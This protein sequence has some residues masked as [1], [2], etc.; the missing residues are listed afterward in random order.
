VKRYLKYLLH[1][2]II[3]GLVVAATKYL[4]GEEILRALK[5]FR[6]VYAPVILLLSTAYIVSKAWRFAILMRPLSNLPWNIFMRG[7]LAGTAATLLPG[8]VTARAGLMKQAGV[9][10]STS[11]APVAFS[12]ILDTAAFVSGLI[13]AALWFDA[14]R[15]P[16]LI[17]MV[18]LAVFGLIMFV[19]ATR[20]WLSR[21]AEWVAGKFH[22][23]EGWRN[24]LKSTREVLTLDIMLK[25]LAISLV[26]VILQV[27]MLDLSLRGLGHT[28]PLS[29]LFL[30]YILPTL[31]GRNSALPAGLGLTEAGMV[32]FL[33]SLAEI[34]VD[35]AAA[36]AAIF[37]VSTV[38]FQALL[39]VLVYFLAWKGENESVRSTSTGKQV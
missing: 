22:V 2:V 17:V 24:L 18:A 19:P 33:S 25:G 6:Y 35:A 14:A 34:D 1:A 32:G 10:L 36:V 4:N 7:Y 29:V 31:L 3:I 23:L 15:L 12:S 5:T 8:G 27:I 39:G 26:G 21:V 37:R 38:F 9:P 30:A 20:D 28:A 16:V 13:F 11:G